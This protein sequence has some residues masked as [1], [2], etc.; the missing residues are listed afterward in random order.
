MYSVE[1]TPGPASDKMR[2]EV[3]RLIW[4]AL[5]QM[6]DEDDAQRLEALI[7]QDKL[8]RRRYHQCAKIHADLYNYFQAGLGLPA[9]SPVLTSLGGLS[10]QVGINSAVID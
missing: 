6:I 9:R 8:V 10:P 7:R 2:D 5:D 3:E 1:N 4:A